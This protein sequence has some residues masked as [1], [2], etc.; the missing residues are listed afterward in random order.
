MIAVGNSADGA[1]I[2]IV[3]RGNFSLDANGLVIL[4]LALGVVT[5]GLAGLLA[6]QGFWPI[7]VIAVTQLILV[8]WLLIRVWKNNWVIE[9]ICI[10]RYGVHIMRQ[11]YRKQRHHHL[12]SAWA[13]VRFEQPRPVWHTPRLL[14]RSRDQQ[15]ELGAFLTVEEKLSLAKHLSQALSGHNAWR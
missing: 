9:E 12:E 7:L 4:I 6:W 13:T 2:R 14:L 10:D 15:V 8:S 1:Q 3:A 11:R 5:L